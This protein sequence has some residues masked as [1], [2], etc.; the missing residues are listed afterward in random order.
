[1]VKMTDKNL[2]YFEELVLNG[3]SGTIQEPI[4]EALNRGVRPGEIMDA[5]NNAMDRASEMWDR[6]EI[7]LPD[8]VRIAEVMKEGLKILSPY[9]RADEKVERILGKIVLGT[10]QGDIHDIGRH[11]VGTL[12]SVNGFEVLDLGH[13]IPAQ[14]FIDKAEE[15]NA[16]I[17]ALSALM[18]TSM[19]YQ[20]DVIQ[21]L[22]DLGQKGK[23]KVMIGG[24]PVTFEWAKEIGADGYGRTALDAVQ[25]AKRLLSA[26]KTPEGIISEGALI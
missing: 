17:I 26:E 16:D 4:L 3:E 12:L 11:V 25:L 18:T 14:S 7:Y 13:D 2:K 15:I 20:Q 21:L 5:M 24:G 1:M 19:P 8:V 22:D 9:I 23:Y 6:L 10:V